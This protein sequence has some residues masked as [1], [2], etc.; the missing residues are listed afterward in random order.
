[1][2]NFK[3]TFGSILDSEKGIG[4]GFDTM[5]VVLSISILC[6]HSIVVS[7]GEAAEAPIWSIPIIGGLLT[8]L[9]PVFFTLSGF[10]V[11]GSA[12]R[13]TSTLDFLKLRGLRIIPALSTEITVSAII[14]GS[15]VTTLSYYHYFTNYEFVRYFWSLTGNIKFF[16]PGVFETN[17][18]PGVVN[19]SLW[20]IGPEMLCYTYISMIMAAGIISNRIR[21]TILVCS[22]I[23]IGII[24]DG[25]GYTHR[26][27][28][29]SL[30]YPALVFCFASGNVLYL[31]RHYIPKNIFIFIAASIIGFLL[32]TINKTATLA[33]PFLAYSTVYL[34]TSRL[35]RIPIL[36]KG[37]YSYGIY[38]YAMPVQQTLAYVFPAL[39]EWYW[40]IVFGLPIVIALAMLSWHWVEKPTLQLRK[41][42]PKA[43]AQA[44]GLA[45]SPLLFCTLALYG[46]WLASTQYSIPGISDHRRWLAAFEILLIVT[47]VFGRRWRV[48]AL[49]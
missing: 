36:D 18:L 34:G 44:A 7:Y 39:R 26:E 30:P 43:P 29:K 35:P 38:L 48:A 41:R 12:V 1:M 49:P 24:A 46:L 6:W 2:I 14:L 19:A 33:T 17:P 25:M 22:F 40:D 4:P 37:D 16:L 9:L 47:T 20:T 32:I 21:V 28:G 8:A 27:L 5:R 45:P 11:M 10:L 13:T 31:W 3:E 23:L 42:I 15:S